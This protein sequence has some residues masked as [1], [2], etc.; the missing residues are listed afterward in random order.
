VP[1][2]TLA[3]LAAGYL[4]GSIPSAYL[5][6][7]W[8]R[9]VDIRRVGSGNVGGSNLRD[10]VGV[11]ATVLVGLVDIAKAAL[12]AWLA[13]A[14][15]LGPDT[16]VWVGVAAVAGH[17]WSPWLRFQGGRG[18]AC[19]LGVLLV[20]FP[21]GVAWVLGALALGAILGEVALFNGLG[22]LTLPLLSRW[23]GE[24]AAVTGLSLGLAALMIV[25][26]LEANRGSAALDVAGPGVLW[27]RLLHDRDRR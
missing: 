6:A 16:A 4:S 12:P 21:A 10:V 18:I 24:P 17:N 22:L 13:E 7:R 1:L 8:R 14:S 27:N 26:R 20:L 2:P 11:W 25:K 9:G 15:G 23:L 19:S 3:F 5:L